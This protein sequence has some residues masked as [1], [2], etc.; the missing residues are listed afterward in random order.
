MM[1]ERSSGPVLLV[2]FTQCANPLGLDTR[3]PDR[4]ELQS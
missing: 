2:P 3:I 1:F 4:F